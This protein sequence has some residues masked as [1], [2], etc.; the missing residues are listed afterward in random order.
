VPG[1]G[2][3]LAV[4]HPNVNMASAAND[5]RRATPTSKT[6]VCLNVPKQIR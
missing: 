2:E 4:A 6:C 3:G 1:S 5:H